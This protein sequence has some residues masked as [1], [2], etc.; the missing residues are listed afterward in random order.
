MSNNSNEADFDADTVFL[1][2][3]PDAAEMARPKLG[4]LGD[5]DDS[6]SR[7]RRPNRIESRP[8]RERLGGGDRAI[9]SLVL[10]SNGVNEDECSDECSDWRPGIN[11]RAVLPKME[12]RPIDRLRLGSRRVLVSFRSSSSLS[13]SVSSSRRLP[14]EGLTKRNDD[15]R[16]DGLFPVSG[17]GDNA[18]WESLRADFGMLRPCSPDMR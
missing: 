4:G 5:V 3:E 6:V 12:S 11:P 15:A 13:S 1:S 2:T 10:I 8:D 7:L 9:V 14:G 18:D 17:A 16:A